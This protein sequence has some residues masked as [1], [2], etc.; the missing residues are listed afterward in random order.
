[1]PSEL[2][3]W[4]AGQ[5]SLSLGVGAAA[6]PA[7]AAESHLSADDASAGFA[8]L[9][10]DDDWARLAAAAPPSSSAA[11]YSAPSFDADFDDFLGGTATGPGQDVCC[12]SRLVPLQPCTASIA[13][14]P[15]VAVF[16]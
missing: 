6:A 2:N 13:V 12:A 10:T 5:E 11:A 15:C 9:Q 8:A 7:A 3:G 14:L 16:L 4:C 1:M